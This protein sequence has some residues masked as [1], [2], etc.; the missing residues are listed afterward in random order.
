MQRE[1]AAP[2]FTKKQILK[3]PIIFSWKN[4]ETAFMA[5]SDITIIRL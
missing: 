3:L 5:F 2:I 1:K 4:V